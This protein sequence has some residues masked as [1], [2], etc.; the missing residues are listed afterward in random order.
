METTETLIIMFSTGRDRATS[1]YRTL[2]AAPSL[3]AR[4]ELYRLSAPACHAVF[5]DYAF[6]WQDI[7]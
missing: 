6:A 5:P 3:S 7:V 4:S 2:L 1:G